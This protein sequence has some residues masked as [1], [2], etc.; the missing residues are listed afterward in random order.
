M[1][2]IDYIGRGGGHKKPEK[3]VQNTC[4]VP[5]GLGV[6]MFGDL[7]VKDDQLNE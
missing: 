6:M 5:Y 1:I 7:E 2:T 4:T 3:G